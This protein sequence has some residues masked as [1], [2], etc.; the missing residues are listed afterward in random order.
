MNA[1]FKH[2]LGSR[3]VRGGIFSASQLSSSQAWLAS[4]AFGRGI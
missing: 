4:G 3:L 1:G 2:R